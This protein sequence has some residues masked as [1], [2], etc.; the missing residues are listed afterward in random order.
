MD[1]WSDLSVC[2]LFRGLSQ[3]IWDD[4][5]EA[6]WELEFARR[7]T[8][9]TPQLFQSGLGVV[10]EGRVEVTRGGMPMDVIGP[11][12]LWGAMSLFLGRDRYPTT[13]TAQTPGR[14]LVLPEERV[15]EL[16][17]RHPALAR[18]YIQ[19]LTE[20]VAFLSD[21][22][23]AL[24]A[25]AAADKLLCYLRDRGG[26]VEGLP[27]AKLA[28]ALGLSRATLYRAMDALEGRGLIARS[29]RTLSLISPNNQE[30]FL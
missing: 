11:G 16:L 17:E 3:E 29:G 7:D 26:R 10:L 15:T 6:A 22:L 12:G 2:P 19:Y 8:L 21:R 27:T 30:E 20:R 18:R 1:E 13:L 14:A 9:A 24:G 5:L 23:D 4:V 28:A 25:G